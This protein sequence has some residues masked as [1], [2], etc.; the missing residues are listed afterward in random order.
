MN[1]AGPSEGHVLVAETLRNGDVLVLTLSGEIDI[2]TA[3]ALR[4]DI[5]ELVDHRV[6]RLL[7]D[8]SD[9]G[10]CDSTG[11]NVLLEFWRVLNDLN[12]TLALAGAPPNVERAVRITGL[13]LSIDL[14]PDL[15]TALTNLHEGGTPPSVDSQM[16]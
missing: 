8:F 7:L 4:Q 9:V 13:D 6:R 12:G 15:P 11:L 16:S 5:A 3:P 2:A 14:N 1:N 10:F